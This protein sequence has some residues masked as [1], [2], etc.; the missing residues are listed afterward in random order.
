MQVLLQALF[1]DA[2][3]GRTPIIATEDSAVS[4]TAFA[5]LLSVDIIDDESLVGIAASPGEAAQTGISIPS[6][7][8]ALQSEIEIFLPGSEL[9]LREQGLED[10]VMIDITPPEPGPAPEQTENVVITTTDEAPEVPDVTPGTEEVA[11]PL[12][13]A[14][15]GRSVNDEQPGLGRDRSALKNEQPGPSP[16]E[17][18]PLKQSEDRTP[19]SGDVTTEPPRFV[20]TGTQSGN[21]PAQP[22]EQPL[23]PDNV[24]KPGLATV[25]ESVGE[26]TRDGPASREAPTPNRVQSV[27][28]SLPTAE[29]GSSVVQAATPGPADDR[30]AARRTELPSETAKAAPSTGSTANTPQP[31]A[32]PPEPLA[33]LETTSKVFANARVPEAA[34][35][36]DPLTGLPISSEA[37]EVR[38]KSGNAQPAPMPQARAVTNQ[39]V[40][41]FAR[42]TA[43]GTVEVR[44]Q[45]EELGRVRLALSPVEAGVTVHISAER[46]D[47]LDLLRRHVDLLANDLLSQGYENLSFSFGQGN[48][49]H[50]FDD[51]TDTT[52]TA[53]DGPGVLVED[54]PTS[55][56]GNDRR[57]DIRL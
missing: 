22:E 6:Q 51:Q 40:Q 21:N 32:A 5:D 14:L 57:L 18:T 45:P 56:I 3:K 29:A 39:I 9:L 30:K 12:V 19:R 37:E 23:K 20:P 7:E 42:A 44:L 50:K 28:P 10:S 26:S 47:T 25:Q 53:S 36:M 35:T 31:V 38:S 4:D 11:Q 8:D 48:A 55:S 41:L 2:E 15:E 17:V 49:Q 27:A 46:Q 43:E 1:A 52:A 16:S 13:A 54:F 24:G 33:A 34:Q